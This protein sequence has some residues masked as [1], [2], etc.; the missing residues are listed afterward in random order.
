M[1]D[2]N[3]RVASIPVHPA[4]APED[5]ESTAAPS[6]AGSRRSA[7]ATPQRGRPAAAPKAQP[8]VAA[9][10]RAAA[11]AAAPA[12]AVPARAERPAV[13]AAA[14][15][16]AAAPQPAGASAGP[17]PAVERRERDPA[18][19]T[20]PRKQIRRAVAMDVDSAPEPPLGEEEGQ[21]TLVWVPRWARPLVAP[22]E[23]YER[24]PPPPVT[25]PPVRAAAPSP[26]SEQPSWSE[27]EWQTWRESRWSGGE[28]PRP[29]PMTPPLGPAGARQPPWVPAYQEAGGALRTPAIGPSRTLVQ[30]LLQQIPTAPLAPTG[31]VSYT[32]AEASTQGASPAMLSEERLAAVLASAMAQAFSQTPVA[33]ALPGPGQAA[34]SASAPAQGASW[35]SAW[36][37]SEGWWAGSAPTPWAAFGGGFMGREGL[38]FFSRPFPSRSRRFGRSW[39]GPSRSLT[40]RASHVIGSGALHLAI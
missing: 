23:E 21:W 18:S 25:S 4:A 30:S 37:Q 11:P 8:A 34:A 36:G 15:S 26:T 12:P 32:G 31:A 33:P 40:V 5:P 13:A 19:G 29:S 16:A 1:D 22:V 20:P 28:C 10:P 9:Q 6:S 35:G 14:G 17:S 3:A 39:F 38:V 2:L 24:F 7:S 27:A